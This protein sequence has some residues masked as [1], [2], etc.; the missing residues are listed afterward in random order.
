MSHPIPDPNFE[1]MSL[2]TKFQMMRSGPGGAAVT[3][4]VDGLTRLEQ[5]L[6]ESVSTTQSV[7]GDVGVQW[8]GQAASNFQGSLGKSGSWAQTTSQAP[9]MAAPTCRPTPPPTTAPATPSPTRPRPGPSAKR[10][11]P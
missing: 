8:Q 10:L 11:A 7:L 6:N 9:F 2:L 5:A 4:T 3:Q 1:G